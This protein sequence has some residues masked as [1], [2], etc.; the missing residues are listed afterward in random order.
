MKHVVKVSAKC[1]GAISRLSI[2]H[3]PGPDFADAKADFLNA[4]YRAWSDFV[5]AKKNETGL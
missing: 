3:T 1:E 5:F 2:A 4:V